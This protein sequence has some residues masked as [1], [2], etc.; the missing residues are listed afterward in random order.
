MKAVK[1]QLA[2]SIVSLLLVLTGCAVKP[3]SEEPLTVLSIAEREAKLEA[4]NAWRVN[5]S[6]S[7]AS[8]K[9][10]KFNAAFSWDAST[11]GFDL[12]LFGPLGVQALRITQTP[13]GAEL[14]D[15]GGEVRADSAEQLLLAATGF[16]VPIS[17]MQIWAVGLPGDGVDV[18]RDEAGRLTGMVVEE[19]GM[20]WNITYPRYSVVD[21]IDL[22]RR[23]EIDSDGVTIKLSLK[24]WIRSNQP[25][26]DRLSIPGAT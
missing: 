9:E 20:A 17:Q 10:G 4:F 15:R 6:I 3:G 7:L 5:G 1:I 23:I 24:R 22:P 26:S 8:E 19:P 13:E 18:Q 14:I 16:T 12:K 25:V 21:G 11:E 2:F